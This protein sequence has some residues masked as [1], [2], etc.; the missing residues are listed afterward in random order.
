MI[1]VNSTDFPIYLM[2]S[3][4]SVKERI[5]V[6]FS[7]LPKYLHFKTEL[8]LEPNDN[9]EVT[10]ILAIIKKYGNTVDFNQLY[11][12]VL[13]LMN[14]QLNIK[15]DIF[16]VW[17]AYNK[18]IPEKVKSREK[19]FNMEYYT[20]LDDMKKIMGDYNI[21]KEYFKNFIRSDMTRIKRRLETKIIAMKSSIQESLQIFNQFELIKEG[22]HSTEFEIESASFNIIL[23]MDTT[24]LMEMF[25]M[26]KLDST[27]PFAS[28]NNYFKV[29]KDFT[30]ITGWGQST[31]EEVM[32]RVLQKRFPKEIDDDDYSYAFIQNKDDTML[33]NIN[34]NPSKLNIK[35]DEYIKRVFNV[36][37]DIPTIKETEDNVKGL[38]YIPGQSLNKYVLSDLIMNNQ[39][40][41]NFLVIDEHDKMTKKRSELI[42]KFKDKKN[43]LITAN[44]TEKF[45]EKSDEIS[46]KSY[47]IFPLGGIYLRVHVSTSRNMEV[48]RNFQDILSKLFKIYNREYT[49]IVD[50]YRQYIPDFAISDKKIHTITKKSKQRFR[51]VAPKELY[52]PAGKKVRFDCNNKPRIVT[53]EEAEEIK[54]SGKGDY[55]IYPK[56]TEYMDKQYMVCT[57]HKDHPYPGLK[58]NPFASKDRLRYLPCCFIDNQKNKNDSYYRKYYDNI[59]ETDTSK[60]GGG[61]DLI[62]T[63]KFVNI[64]QPGV[65]PENITKFFDN[66]DPLGTYYRVGMTRSKNSFLEC[67][68]DALSLG[69]FKEEDTPDISNRK[70]ETLKER[71][72]LVK[73][74]GTG[75]CRQE[76]YDSTTEEIQKMVQDENV[77]LDPKLFIRL[78]ETHYKCNIIIFARDNDN[79]RGHMSLPRF[80][81]SYLK[82]K[83]NNPCIFI[84]EHMGST[85]NMADYPQ[86]EL[87]IKNVNNEK[88][89]YSFLGNDIVSEKV[90]K[91]FEKIRIAYKDN[92]S[93]KETV[94]DNHESLKFI[95]QV[96]DPC[97]KCR[98]LHSKFD[99]KDISLIIDP[100]PPLAIPEVRN[101][102]LKRIDYTTAKSLIDTLGMILTEQAVIKGISTELICKY[103]NVTV[104]IPINNITP[105]KS[106]KISNKTILNT[107]NL[108]ILDSFNYRKKTARYI[109]EYIIWLFSKYLYSNGINYIDDQVLNDF[110]EKNIEVNTSFKYGDVPKK[111]SMNSSLMQRGKLI[112]RSEETLK[113]L[114][115]VLRIE[116]IRRRKKVI[117]YH[118][119][120]M[121]D[122]YY[123]DITD[124]DHYPFQTIIYGD[125]SVDNL[126][127]EKYTK[128]FTTHDMVIPNLKI[129]YFFKNKLISRKI[130][131]AQN[132][133]S[134]PEAYNIVYNWHEFKYNP[135]YFNK[136]EEPLKG[137]LYSYKSTSDISVFVIDGKENNY[138][139]KIIGYKYMENDNITTGFTVLLPIR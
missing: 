84:F 12:K 30:P 45:R 139:M 133:S 36:L 46:N 68:L 134:M 115:Y 15:N 76:L 8:K 51:D 13:P 3:E 94:F 53:K 50:I 20:E 56:D 126:I 106:I 27:I 47:N 105:L 80:S 57:E 19:E 108:S 128:Q 92:K 110:V 21:D 39:M 7:S 54:I 29:I 26:L 121:I 85:S 25:N 37:G 114:I 117:N 44:I 87:I 109:T 136:T 5:A 112:I 135:G 66:I 63:K 103:G 67:V 40:F 124:F 38:F 119:H 98:I 96:I 28:F 74:A 138:D 14:Q 104:S 123:M 130:F 111:F 52:N 72:L 116:L 22:V 73:L 131:L 82:N 77:Y 81:Q 137:T 69:I 120:D 102:S 9:N 62:T 41:S 86:C 61:K 107:T 75:I 129:P 42:V 64:K 91:M 127:K 95:S 49:T 31:G 33:L 101:V 88:S 43:G 71:L 97:G 83:N 70:R 48:V 100:I 17:L 59:I 78:I 118:S 79:E 99:N 60:G 58:V 89:F 32:L 18:E 90:K 35:K 65:L 24:S 1:K 10:D 122:N 93:I 113:R 132:T 125:D 4:E 23:N 6:E 16:D 34:I 55:M 2:D 11:K